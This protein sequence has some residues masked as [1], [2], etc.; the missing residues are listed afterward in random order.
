[1]NYPAPHPLRIFPPSL[2]NRGWLDC[3]RFGGHFPTEAVAILGAELA[4]VLLMTIVCRF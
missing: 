2:T 1:M 4:S 3:S